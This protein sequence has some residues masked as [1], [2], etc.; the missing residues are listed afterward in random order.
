MDV[1]LMYELLTMYPQRNYRVAASTTH[2]PRNDWCGITS[3]FVNGVADVVVRS[4][5]SG[6]GSREAAVVGEV[7]GSSSASEGLW[8]RVAIMQAMAEFNET[9]SVSIVPSM[10]C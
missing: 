3:P 8:Q 5:E 2:H 10:T 1:G 9:W 4:L 6:S 7:K